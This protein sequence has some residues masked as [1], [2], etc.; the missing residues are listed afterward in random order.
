MTKLLKKAFSE[1]SRLSNKEQ[2]TL[3]K[4]VLAEI[5]SEHRWNKLFSE[6]Q[7]GLAKLAKDTLAKHHSKKTKRLN[8]DDL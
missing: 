1:A 7:D 8:V 4:R 6:T 3:A 2:N 5:K